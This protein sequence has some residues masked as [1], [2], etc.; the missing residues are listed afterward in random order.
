MDLIIF[1]ERILCAI[2]TF[3][4]K[5]YTLMSL[6]KQYNTEHQFLIDTWTN[7]SLKQQ[8]HRILVKI[9]SAIRAKGLILT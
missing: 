7:Y 9:G 8:L 6:L 4:H 3:S 2:T 1:G 5:Y